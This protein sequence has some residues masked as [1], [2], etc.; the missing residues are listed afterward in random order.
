MTGVPYA[1]FKVAK[2]LRL[3]KV[4]VVI[5]GALL[6]M[7]LRASEAQERKLVD[8][9]GA[10]D[11]RTPLV[12][13]D[14]QQI[15]TRPQILCPGSFPSDL[16]TTDCSFTVG[17]RLENLVSGSL[18]DQAMAG[19][20]FYGLMAQALGTPGEWHRNLEGYGYR[21]G[22]RYNQSVAKG[23]AQFLAGLILHDDPRHVSYHDEPRH[24]AKYLKAGQGQSANSTT[25]AMSSDSAA[26]PGVWKRSWHAIFDSITVRRSS[27]DGLGRRM[28]A[29]S[30]FAADFGSAYGGYAWYRGPENKFQKAGL[31]AAGSLGSDLVSSFYTEYK[32]EIGRLLGALFNRGGTKK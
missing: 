9:P 27:Q 23:S 8:E 7:L 21:V 2:M 29:F 28:P 4:Q 19:A 30:R 12:A 16:T 11:A 15:A 13:E 3:R 17:K 24:Y 10:I 5:G 22:V 26:N 18:T 6:C 32:P 31:R 14:A 25:A 20:A 1:M